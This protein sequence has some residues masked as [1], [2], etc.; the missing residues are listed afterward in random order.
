MVESQKTLDDR[1]LVSNRS[2]LTMICIGMMWFS[3]AADHALTGAFCQ[4]SAS[5]SS[6]FVFPLFP[7][8]FLPARAPL[9]ISSSLVS[10][11]Q[12]CLQTQLQWWICGCSASV[13]LTSW[14][15]CTGLN[16]LSISLSA[17]HL[18]PPSLLFSPSLCLS[19][20]FLPSFPP[21]LS[22]SH[23]RWWGIAWPPASVMEQT[24][25]TDPPP[26]PT[27]NNKQELSSTICQ[28]IFTGGISE[29]AHLT[30]RPNG[31]ECGKQRHWVCLSHAKTLPV[32]VTSLPCWWLWFRSWCN[33]TTSN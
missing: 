33:Y 8:L 15:I 21:S 29:I 6:Q 30:F 9:L 10:C 27:A 28:L 2:L 19:I 7:C 3:Y 23:S 4:I 24:E 26:I 5:C 13:C 16:S 32:S 31:S 1:P 22:F 18:P 20:S 14:C 11:V 25:H 17:A 12:L